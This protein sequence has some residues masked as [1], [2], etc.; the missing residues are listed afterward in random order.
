[1]Q[2]LVLKL[3]NVWNV[4]NQSLHLGRE[5]GGRREGGKREDMREGGERREG[6]KRVYEVDNRLYKA[7]E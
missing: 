4:A 5:K 6:E 1:M 3:E 2:E 7:G